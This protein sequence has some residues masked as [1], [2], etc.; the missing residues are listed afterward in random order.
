[1]RKRSK[2][3]SQ[4]R[5]V[6]VIDDKIT[7]LEARIDKRNERLFELLFRHDDLVALVWMA[8][9]GDLSRALTYLLLASSWVYIGW[10]PTRR[11]DTEPQTPRPEETPLDAYVLLPAPAANSHSAEEKDVHDRPLNAPFLEPG[12]NMDQQII[13]KTPHRRKHSPRRRVN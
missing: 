2:P 11:I 5:K 13:N 6:P 10:H 3:R 7:S 1:M 4:G 12:R 9:R 8:F